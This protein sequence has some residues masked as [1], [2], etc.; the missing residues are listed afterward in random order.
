MN[1]KSFFEVWP[2]ILLFDLLRYFIP[3]SLAFVVFYIICRKFFYPFLIQGKFPESRQYWH[4]FGYSMSTVVIFALVGYCI[5]VADHHGWTRI[6]VHLETFGVPYTILSFITTLLFHDFYFYWTHRIMHHRSL[7][8][9][10]HRVHHESTNPSPWAAYAFHPWE[11]LIQASVLPI[12]VFLL[13][14]HPMVIFLFLTYMIL[15]NVAGH[16]GFEIL[17]RGFTRN[18]WLNWN[19]AITHHNMHHEHFHSNY[20][21]YFT[22]WD[23]WMGTEHEK[24]HDAFDR[25]RGKPKSCKTKLPKQATMVFLVLMVTGGV[26]AQ[27]VVGEW[28]THHEVT[29]SPLAIIEIAQSGNSI[30]GRVK[31]I[32][33]MPHEGQDPV[34]AQCS[35]ARRNQKIFGMNLLWGLLRDGDT[36]GPGLI[37]DPESGV[38]YVCKL[39]M[40]GPGKLRVRG[41]AGPFNLFYR[42]QTWE[43]V[44]FPTGTPEGK[45]KTIDDH[46]NQPKAL[47]E[48][49]ARDGELLGFVR[50]IYALPHTGPDAVCLACKGEQKNARIV[51]MKILWDF[52][53]EGM[54]WVNG[55]IM[56]PANGWTYTS[57]IWLND[58]ET[59]SVRGY[60]GPFYR[61]QQWKRIH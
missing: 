45:W 53:Q 40:D 58:G 42:T 55:K 32:F 18:R 60:L 43:R 56:D 38:E 25:V 22:W 20:G 23:K 36:W 3:A 57:S 52:E 6:Y 11:A 12:M 5:Y 31:Q 51:G 39:W 16:L 33:P 41:Y 30:E 35:G 8:R 4:E 46:W 21:L 29:G 34:C 9:H 59:L 1:W 50:E 49:I 28:V 47:V 27:S 24:Y 48:I 19:T 17:P 7:F 13:P 54:R 61:T 2:H 44:G 10:V 26:Q 14:L 37:V 15:R